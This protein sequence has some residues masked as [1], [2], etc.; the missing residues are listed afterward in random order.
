MTKTEQENQTLAI[1]INAEKL[2]FKIIS[3]KT[4][5]GIITK[6]KIAVLSG[7]HPGQINAFMQGKKGLTS[8]TIQKISVGISKLA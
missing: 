6:H 2:L 7:I 5:S 3:E 1:L 4:K 8:A